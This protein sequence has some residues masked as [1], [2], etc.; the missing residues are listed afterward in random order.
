M[1]GSRPNT[2]ITPVILP[3][4]QYQHI[5]QI[6]EVP[7]IAWLI[8]FLYYQAHTHI[9]YWQKNVKIF[10]TTDLLYSWYRLSQCS[11]LQTFVFEY[12]LWGPLF[13]DWS[14]K[15][16]TK[17]SKCMLKRTCVSEI[18]TQTTCHFH[19]YTYPHVITIQPHILDHISNSYF[20][21]ACFT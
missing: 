16:N 6:H 15:S 12:V 20:L 14:W 17:L 11:V 21:H 3:S 9:W 13:F 5:T 18:Q 7:V 10:K 1:A 4:H 8:V 19:K 2:N